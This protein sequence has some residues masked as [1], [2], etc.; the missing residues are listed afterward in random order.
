MRG[1]VL[2]LAVL[3]MLACSAEAAILYEQPAPAG[4]FTF[5]ATDFPN[6]TDPRP[7]T[8]YGWGFNGTGGSRLDL[9]EH[10]LYWTLETFYESSPTRRAMEHH[11][12]Y[13]H[14]S[15]YN[16]R[17][18]QMDFDRDTNESGLAFAFTRI[19][20]RG[21]DST[22]PPWMTWFDGEA[23]LARTTAF[24]HQ[25]NN[26]RWLYQRNASGSASGALMWLDNQD[27]YAF[28]QSPWLPGGAQAPRA[29]L[30]NPQDGETALVLMRNVGGVVTNQS[31]TLGPPD[32]AG[33]GYRALRVVN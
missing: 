27:R 26:V 28:G 12:V 20:W 3:F 22:Q 5:T 30:V 8:V 23:K 9:S 16:T 2:A 17:A 6:L 11:L 31:V 1:R 15:G 29:L 25:T 32:S 21:K 18:I 24:V 10:M 14:P 7:N 13:A 19:D 33:V 4:A